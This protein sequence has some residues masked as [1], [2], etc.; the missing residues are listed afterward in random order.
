MTSFFF[1]AFYFEMLFNQQ[2]YKRNEH[3]IAII[4]IDR[5]EREKCT[6]SLLLHII[7]LLYHHVLNL[8]E[9]ETCL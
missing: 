2:K 9:N 6:K 8:N 3:H 5:R 1:E 7:Q 4:G